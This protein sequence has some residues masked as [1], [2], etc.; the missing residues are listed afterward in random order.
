MKKMNTSDLS[1]F[2]ALDFR[3]TKIVATIGPA[4][5]SE[6]RIRQLIT[7]GVNVMRFNTKH[8]QP[9]WHLQ[10]IERVQAIAYEMRVPIGILLDLQGPEI[11]ITLSK[12]DCFAAAKDST[13]IFTSTPLQSADM[14]IQIPQQVIESLE[15]GNH[16]ILDDGNCEMV[17]TAKQRDHFEVK[18]LDDCTINTRKTMNTPGVVMDMPSL[19][20]T[21]L[22]YLDVLKKSQIGFVALSFVRDEHDIQLLKDELIKRDMHAEVIA[23]IENQKAL[24]NLDSIIAKSDGVMVARGDLAVEVN[25]EELAFWQKKIIKKCQQIGKP[26]ITATQM[27]ASM[28]ESSHPTRAEIC[29]VANSVYDGTD[30][31]MLSEETTYGK[32]PIKT[33]L[34]QA[35]I[36]SFYE[37][38]PIVFNVPLQPP[39]DVIALSQ[40]IIELLHNQPE[41]IQKMIV[42]CDD[43]TLVHQLTRYRSAVP[44]LAVLTN[45]EL[46]QK[47]SLS[48]GVVPFCVVGK[49]LADLSTEDVVALLR[50]Q[51][52]VASGEKVIFASCLS[53]T[54]SY[55]QSPVIFDV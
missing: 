42:S 12:G 52:K 7:A 24:D 41:P 28:A 49:N 22:H 51:E 43:E 44:L 40:K 30:A 29:D 38:Q 34:T 17:I 54:A 19:L 3:K 55:K 10:A 33:V 25:F 26:V 14:V 53:A 15:V 39:S 5:E 37:K 50:Q 1:I 47:L 18:I 4:T 46:A 48:Y 16:I 27:L 31:V 32:Y 36:V 9:E 13:V 35:K 23:K 20:P 11:R 45:L 8:N 2:S 21:D 6:D